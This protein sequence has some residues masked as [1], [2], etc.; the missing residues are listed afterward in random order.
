MA[1]L[2]YRSVRYDQ[3][4]RKR[5]GT[6]TSVHGLN[7]LFGGRGEILAGQGPTPNVLLGYAADLPWLTVGARL[8]GSTASLMSIDGGLASK[9]YELGLAAVLQRYVDLPWFSLAFG[10]AIEGTWYAQRFA[11]TLRQVQSRN[12]FGIGFSALFALER[13][14]FRGVGI[15]LEGG[16]SASLLN[17]AVLMNGAEQTAQ[18]RSVFTWWLAGGGIWR[19]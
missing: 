17:Q 1:S 14:M 11:P 19:F 15:R 4:V 6:R 10:V 8:R 2:P 7:L 3:L 16:P 5:G 9:Q 18:T 13:Q 12:S